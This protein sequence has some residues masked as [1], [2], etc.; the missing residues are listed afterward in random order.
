MPLARTE[1]I[2]L[3]TIDWSETSLIAWLFTRERGRLHVLAKGARRPRSPFEGA[4]EPLV[5]GE[6]VSYQ[7]KKAG[8][9]LEIAKEFDP[10]DRHTGLRKDLPRLYRGLYL[11]ELLLELSERDLP[12]HETFDAASAALAGLCR[13]EPGQ[14]DRPLFRCELLLLRAAGLSPRLDACARCGGALPA[15]AEPVFSPAAGGLLCPAHAPREREALP[16]SRGALRTLLA[17]DQGVDVR[18]GPDSSRELRA[19]LD[20]F[21]T[22]HLERP[23][24]MAGTLREMEAVARARTAAGRKTEH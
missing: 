23:L 14:L 6:L 4:L 15:T 13:E 2:V 16:L 9:G 3:R 10:L 18:L 21:F 8:D 1:A 7:R 12:S 17:L 19:L 20:A 5:R 22:W 11:G 24:R